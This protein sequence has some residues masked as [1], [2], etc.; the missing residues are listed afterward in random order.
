MTLPRPSP[1]P[2]TAWLFKFLRAIPAVRH[3][4]K[5][6]SAKRNAA[7]IKSGARESLHLTRLFTNSFLKLL[8]EKCVCVCMYVYLFAFPHPREQ[9]FYLKLE[10]SLYTNNKSQCYTHAQVSSGVFILYLYSIL[11]ITRQATQLICL[12]CKSQMHIVTIIYYN[13]KLQVYNKLRIMIIKFTS[14][15]ISYNDK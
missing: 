9:T 4:K 3:V 2:N 11:L 5:D 6:R 8:Y 10:S 13:Y 12:G 7:L 1:C 15:S 14:Y